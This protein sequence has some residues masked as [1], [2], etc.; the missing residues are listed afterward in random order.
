MAEEQKAFLV[1]GIRT[2][3]VDAET[4]QMFNSH[5]DFMRNYNERHKSFASEFWDSITTSIQRSTSNPIDPLSS[6]STQQR[7]VNF[8]GALNGTGA[9]YSRDN[10]MNWD[11]A[12]KDWYATTN[13]INS[14]VNSVQTIVNT[15]TRNAF[16]QQEND[17]QTI[18]SMG[19]FAENLGQDP[20]QV[21]SIPK[22]LQKD[23]LQEAKLRENNPQWSQFLQQHKNLAEWLQNEYNYAR[24]KDDIK[25]QSTV[26][27]MLQS[28][29]LGAIVS[30][31]R[32]ERAELYW[33]LGNGEALSEEQQARARILGAMIKK[34]TDKDKNS[35][36]LDT[37][38]EGLGGMAVPLG[39]AVNTATRLGTA[40]AIVGAVGGTVGSV[41]LASAGTSAGFTGGFLHAMAVESAGN[42][43][44][45]VY[46]KTGQTPVAS[47]TL[48]AMTSAVLN[49][50]G[51]KAVNK[52][53][54]VANKTGILKALSE[55]GV[56]TF[57]FNAGTG[58][59]EY[60]VDEM[61]R[62]MYGVNQ[63][64]TTGELLYN[65][66]VNGVA[67]GLFSTLVS[68]PAFGFAGLRMLK[69]QVNQTNLM[70]RG[71]VDT[72]AELINS[73][74]RGTPL[75]T[76]EIPPQELAEYLDRPEVTDQD[77][78][79]FRRFVP[80]A[81]AFDFANQTGTY[82]DVPLGEFITANDNMT[83][84]LL[85]S[86]RF[87]GRYSL[88]E[89]QKQIQ[90][91]EA[92]TEAQA[93]TETD[94]KAEQE[95]SP[96]NAGQI[97]EGGLFDLL[98]ESGNEY[99]KQQDSKYTTLLKGKARKQYTKKELKEQQEERQDMQAYID[100][101]PVY[102]ATKDI[103]A[104]G[105]PVIK[106]I[107]DN[108]DGE[109]KDWAKAHINGFDSDVEQSFVDNV[110]LD[111]GYQSGGHMLWSII[112]SPT[113]AEA[114]DDAFKSVDGMQNFLRDDTA[115]VKLDRFMDKVF[116]TAKVLN[117]LSKGED[118]ETKGIKSVEEIETKADMRVEQLNAQIKSLEGELAGSGVIGSKVQ[119]TVKDARIELLK[120]EVKKVKESK[121][122]EIQKVRRDTATKLNARLSQ[123]VEKEKQK[124]T[125]YK[126]N[127]R[128]FVKNMNFKKKSAE[129]GLVTPK[130]ANE[131]AKHQ[132]G[133]M[134]IGKIKKERDKITTAI[135]Q[136]AIKANR[137]YLKYEYFQGVELLNHVISGTA[138]LKQSLRALQ[139]VYKTQ[140]DI[141]KFSRMRP[142]KFSNEQAYAQ[143]D[144]IL[145]K[146]G[147][148]KTGSRPTVLVDRTLNQFF[149]E[150][151]MRTGK[152]FSM[153]SPMAQF[154]DVGGYNPINVNELT[155]SQYKD[156]LTLLQEIKRASDTDKDFYAS[157][158]KGTLNG[159]IKGMVQDIIRF[160]PQQNDG[161]AFNPALK[162]EDRTAGFRKAVN[163][164]Q[165]IV[166]PEN[167]LIHM[168]GEKSF[169]YKFFSEG[170]MDAGDNKAKISQ[171][172]I[173][174]LNRLNNLYTKSEQR[175]M[176]NKN[177]F[178]EEQGGI[179]VSK[180]D[181]IGLAMASGSLHNWRKIFSIS[182]GSDN[183]PVAFKGSRDWT[184][185][186]VT[187]MLGKYLD[188]R[189]WE[190]VQGYWKI[191]DDLWGNH[192]KDFERKRSGFTPEKA[193][194]HPMSVTL[195]DGT[196]LDLKGGFFPLVKDARSQFFKPASMSN[197]EYIEFTLQ[198]NNLNSYTDY[199]TKQSQYKKRTNK[200]YIVD[201][202]YATI[203]PS[204]IDK[205]V[206]DLA[207]R[208][209]AYT[210]G[211]ILR[212][213]DFRN[214]VLT[215]Y[216]DGG[217]KALDN[218]V[219]PILKEGNP[220]MLTNSFTPLLIYAKRVG[221][222]SAIGNLGTIIQGFANVLTVPYSAKG[223][224]VLDTIRSYYKYGVRGL[225]SDLLTF[226]FSEA[227]AKM[228][229]TYMLSPAFKEA[230]QTLE[231]E[232]YGVYNK[233]RGAFEQFT[234][235]C[236]NAVTT[237]M[238]LIDRVTLQPQYMG[239]IEKFEGEAKSKGLSDEEAVRYAVDKADRAMERIVPS[240]RRYRQSAFA[241]APVGSAVWLVSGL[242]SYSVTMLN[243]L[244]WVYE[245]GV[246]QGINVPLV[247]G[248]AVSFMILAPLATSII[249]GQSPLSSDE[250]E[251]TTP[252]NLFKWGV[253]TV[254]GNVA[255]MFP[256]VGDVLRA[257]VANLTD[258]P[259]YGTRLP[260][261]VYSI[262]E[263][264]SRTVG[265]AV[266]YVEQQVSD[267]RVPKN[268]QVELSSAIEAGARTA[269]M[270][271]GIPIGFSNMIFNILMYMDGTATPE[272]RDILR[273]R[274]FKERE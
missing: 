122:E 233:P 198:D 180:N 109:V 121:K 240:S 185:E 152:G 9:I 23:V 127:L 212:N 136:N 12:V 84:A 36:L 271:T 190:F 218:I 38:S 47:A 140:R 128:D 248:T 118:L 93:K 144:R 187:Q 105:S 35:G 161:D 50:V 39:K 79:D 134:T 119:K 243:R 37:V 117:A 123:K 51:L 255:G 53:Y 66:A 178:I 22:E 148:R 156:A 137:H 217:L 76:V 62:R 77:Q 183:V 91:I 42:Y 226:N 234:Q 241:N 58:G 172:I 264:A 158:R 237:A 111:N 72:Q 242:A 133:F 267:K 168:A 73:M 272:A 150:N 101:Q 114:I 4:G 193:P 159:L 151:G 153:S 69:D 169:L 41:A 27:S 155:I 55:Q 182:E 214:T 20:S 252:E 209:W 202:D 75:E 16:Q 14:G 232:M 269:S 184:E 201:V 1:D 186:G 244:L 259:Y 106:D 10:Y 236:T 223:Y 157:A 80:N 219:A 25:P 68:L 44:G 225:W 65:T 260:V 43:I 71:D 34:L 115:E 6:M 54:E 163:T 257:G 29:A 245:T 213:N 265:T 8:M 81:E 171:P 177:L 249:S 99:F 142:E 273:R 11:N 203:V 87:N 98:D 149:A 104:S 204:Y 135:R 120:E 100:D 179:T 145:R 221:V 110:A 253:N 195:A 175:Q 107:E 165:G 64:Q 15:L 154:W 32:Q 141:A 146:L 251:A 239:M 86:I 130:L 246:K 216:G 125:D 139:E 222:T 112:K 52:A 24:V 188:K 124:L 3:I 258:Q 17:P 181:L 88:D 206:H 247:A 60:L 230:G 89:Y 207:F 67:S 2:R 70:K 208:E 57:A 220:D 85:K 48:R 40:G 235:T 261:G 33:R 19:K 194:L 95:E 274:P 126:N 270:V 229:A 170:V 59:G 164:I 102:K 160:H 162:F 96:V 227:R 173:K 49:G 147:V 30:D 31:L 129:K 192:C 228:E 268:K 21:V 131:N 103:S 174:E 189:D 45:D 92:E 176:S 26:A 211:S 197:R 78:I 63:T 97:T 74:V 196:K 167:W 256:I 13:S 116:N 108:Y 83:D 5:D 61:F 215:R 205:V 138:F 90:D 143:V 224:G 7:A 263:Q 262:T 250:K 266:K 199:M 18:S 82:L 56:K 28:G 200:A 231:N 191:F 46:E 166:N 238:R 113:Y 254:V 94:G 210:A 132:I